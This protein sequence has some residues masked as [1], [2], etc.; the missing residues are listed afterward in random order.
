MAK[1]DFYKAYMLRE[2]TSVFAVWFCIVLLYGVLCLASNPMPGLGILSFIEFFKKPYCSVLKYY[3]AYRNALSY[4][5]I[6]L[7]DTKSDEYHCEK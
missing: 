6:F 2:A 4:G 3:Y 5:D 7:N 1:L